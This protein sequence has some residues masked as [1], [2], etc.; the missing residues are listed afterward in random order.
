[1]QDK[2]PSVGTH[3]VLG[4]QKCQS[5]CDIYYQIFKE[6]ILKELKEGIMAV[7]H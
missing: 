3:T 4:R 6:T 5:Y 2:L 1:M 7:S